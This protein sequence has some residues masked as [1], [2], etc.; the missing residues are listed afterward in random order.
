M[1]TEQW[2]RRE[3]LKLGV[4]ASTVA[5]SP[6][7][8]EAGRERNLALNRAAWASSSA[9]FI[10]TGHMSTDGQPSTKWQSSDADPQWIYVDLGAVCKIGSVV[11]RWGANH[12][13][14]YRLQVSM[15]DGPSPETGLVEGWTEVH[16]TLEGK[17]GVERIQLPETRGRFVR[18][19]LTGK[20]KPGGYELSAFEVYGVGGLEAVPSPVPAPEAD[21]SI[22]LSGGWRLVDQA[23]VT[24]KAQSISTCGYDDSKWLIATVPGTVLTSYLNLGA[25]P[26]PF[27][28]DYLAQISDFFAHTNWWYRNELDLP[29]S[30]EGRRV[31]LNFDGINYRAY[32]FVNGKPAGSIDGA[33]VRGRF[34]VTDLV[35]PGKKNCIAVL[36]LPVPKP[37]KVYPKALSGYS[38]P[39]DYPKNE[40]TILAADSWDWLPTIRDRDTG[41]WNHVTLTT[42]GDVTVENPFAS[43]HFPEPGILKRADLTLRVDVKNHSSRACKG[44][45]KVRIGEIEFTHPVTLDGGETRT[46][47]LDKSSYKQLSLAD[48]KLWWPSGHGEQHLYDL[49]IEFICD[50]R[51]SDVNKSRIGIREFTYNH[52]PLTAWDFSKLANGMDPKDLKEKAVKE[53]I[54]F[55][56]NGKRIFIRGVNWGMDEGMLR[57]D[58]EGFENRVGMEKAMNFNLIRNW[59]GNLDKREFYDVCDEYGI[60]V[61]EEFGMANGLQPDDPGMWLV[62]A[63]D[64]FLRR[65]NHACVLLWCSANETLPDDPILTEMPKMADA[66]DGTRLF[67]QSSIQVPPTNGDSPY[68]T[69]PASYYFKDLARG[70]RPE[71]GSPTV[72]CVESMGRMMPHNKLWPVN[73]MWALHDWWLGTGWDTGNGL[74][75][76]TMN[77]IA[78]YGAPQGIEDFC[79]KA[80]MVN[81][82]V[83]KAIYEAWND[84]MWDD[85]TGVMIWMSNPA[86]PSLTWNTYDYF[87]EPTAAYFACRKACEPLHIQWNA[88]TN[89]V[90]A[91]NCTSRELKGL[92]AEAAIYNLDGSLFQAKSA[93]LDC[94]ANSVQDCMTLF[95]ASED[96]IENL[97]NVHFIKLALK[98]GSGEILSSNFYWRG[99]TEWKYEDLAGMKQ[100]RLNA[101]A[102][103]LKDGKVTVELE[104]PTDG[105]VLMARLKVVDVATGLLAAPVLYSDNYFSLAPRETRRTDIDLQALHPR[106]GVKLVVEGWNT[107][108]MELPG[109]LMF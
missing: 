41:I 6:S 87:M 9:D 105:L 24:D 88:A 62:N 33:F 108:P 48:P 38:W 80:Q 56:C 47:K 104:N 67:L 23:A 19:A 60:L 4:L 92:T 31:W 99:K 59:G 71:L 53:P 63:R 85:C 55:S 64:R 76:S 30:Y 1:R 82:E 12:A 79:R 89:Q 43:T 98:D 73:E 103:A 101:T 39:L 106:R 25:I 13:L 36:I 95:V 42:S 51:V 45:L 100:G 54:A 17:G 11:L 90:K 8:A 34:D 20:A 15:D 14:A 84:R 28:G 22:R 37:D 21:G 77:A 10:N 40:P 57:C 70:F 2:T 44:G 74:C 109:T 93:R 46:L 94:S 5:V 61:W 66:L 32:I 49:T 86:W 78:A 7:W 3:V 52:D 65:R 81:M 97:S 18:V 35:T 83:F 69:R 68:D 58:R 16:Q 29:A 72:P 75:G 102:G 107:A 27:Y 26:D 91:V 50:G 96:K